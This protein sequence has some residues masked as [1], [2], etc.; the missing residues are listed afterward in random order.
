MIKYNTCILL[1]LLLSSC[2]TQKET[3]ALSHQST[4]LM[5]VPSVSNSSTVIL[6]G[7]K[8]DTTRV[9]LRSFTK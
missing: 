8:I 9:E 4:E 1:L 3:E 2:G 7:A 6:S 5:S